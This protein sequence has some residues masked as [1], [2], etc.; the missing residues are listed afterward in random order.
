MLFQRRSL[1]FC[2]AYMVVKSQIYDGNLNPRIATATKARLQKRCETKIY[3]SARS[4]YVC[5]CMCVTV[6]V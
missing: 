4:L 6:C 2:Y 3:K 1:F 5:D